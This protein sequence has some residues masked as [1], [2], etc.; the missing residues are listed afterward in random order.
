MKLVTLYVD[1]DICDEGFTEETLGAFLNVGY[2]LYKHHVTKKLNDVVD[3]NINRIIDLKC[4]EKLDELKKE[5]LDLVRKHVL[6]AE[7]TATVINELKAERKS[8][9]TKIEQLYKSVYEDSVQKLKD[10]LR[11]KEYEISMLKNTNI[12]KGQTGEKSIIAVLQQHFTDAFV[13]NTGKT[14]HLCDVHMDLP[15]QRGRIVF[16]SKY[17]AC[18]EKRD[19]D[20]F[21]R[22]IEEMVE[23]KENV[24]GAVFVS[25]CSRNIP[26]KGDMYYERIAGVP[27]MYV[28]FNSQEEFD[29][30]FG[31][32][33]R[34]FTGMCEMSKTEDTGDDKDNKISGMLEDFKFLHTMFVKNKKRLDDIKAKFMK[35]T[36]DVEQD[37]KLILDKME[38]SIIQVK[39]KRKKAH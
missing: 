28:G 9:Q 25:M 21:V 39:P 13:E 26:H 36:Q 16:E 1:D 37:N 11:Q 6:E 3:G 34:M 12:V 17:K 19:I 38:A 18:I 24:L 15:E 35:Y 5:N 7:Y 20:K 22:D 29:S 31:Q 10:D 2:L 4:S 32:Y 30:V 23:R 33:V 14:A 27:A 8:L